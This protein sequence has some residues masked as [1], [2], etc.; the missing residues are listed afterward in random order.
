MVSGGPTDIENSTDQKEASCTE[1]CCDDNAEGTKVT[2][3]LRYGLVNLPRD[4]G[5]ALLLGIFVAG[6][7]SALVPTDSLAAYIGGGILSIVIM[8][9]V[10]IPVYVCATASVP[11]AAGFIHMGASP[12]AA[13]AFLVAGPATNAAALAAVWKILEKRAAA[14]YLASVAAS[15]VGFG[16]L[17]DVVT[18]FVA[19]ALPILSEHHHPETSP[20]GTIAAVVLLALF[21]HAALTGRTGR[22]PA[23][24]HANDEPDTATASTAIELM[25][26]GMTCGHCAQTVTNTLQAIPG[27]RKVAVDLP[28]KRVVIHGTP[29]DPQSLAQAIRELGFKAKLVT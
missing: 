8:M 19:S 16:L 25:V 4:I 18:P 2:R 24:S 29:P 14:I 7:L 10:G 12:G 28:G 15:A 9:A 21:A 26:T 20:G 22:E 23:H 13:F 6:A 11:I 5:R 1:S 17:L 27:V 3:A